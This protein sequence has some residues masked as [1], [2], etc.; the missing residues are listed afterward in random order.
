[1]AEGSR[2]IG[3]LSHDGRRLIGQS[4]IEEPIVREQDAP[5]AR[6]TWP[7]S[8]GLYSN[9]NPE[10]LRNLDGYRHPRTVLP[11]R[12]GTLNLLDQLFSR[13]G[14]NETNV[15]G[16][17]EVRAEIVADPREGELPIDLGH[18]GAVQAERDLQFRHYSFLASS[19]WIDRNG[20]DWEPVL[21]APRS[22]LATP[23]LGAIRSR[24]AEARVTPPVYRLL[25]G[26]ECVG[27]PS[28]RQGLD[29]L[30]GQFQLGCT[31]VV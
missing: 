5:G 14:V 4:L 15:R 30:T 13:L 25:Q 21:T 7:Q 3:F 10:G 11:A 26:F 18:H 16:V 27:S 20:A 1:M 9:A 29:S 19:A 24:F 23:Q 31:V 2:V 6:E 22:A 8:F 28:T 17:Y 12:Q